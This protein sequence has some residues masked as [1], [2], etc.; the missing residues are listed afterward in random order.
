MSSTPIGTTVWSQLRSQAVQS[1]LGRKAGVNPFILSTFVEGGVGPEEVASIASVRDAREF[2]SEGFMES[3]VAALAIGLLDLPP[4]TP[5][6]ILTRLHR[7]GISVSTSG[8]LIDRFG[9][10]DVHDSFQE[11]L[12]RLQWACQQQAAEAVSHRSDFAG[13]PWVNVWSTRQKLQSLPP[14]LQALYRLR[15]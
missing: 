4:N 9:P 2:S 7:V 15:S 3:I 12:L 5:W 14:E 13:L 10:F 1:T 8:Q 6:A 11:V